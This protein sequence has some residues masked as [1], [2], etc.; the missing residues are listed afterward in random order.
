MWGK[1]DERLPHLLSHSLLHCCHLLRIHVL[2]LAL[3]THT[4]VAL[5]LCKHCLL[6]LPMHESLPLLLLVLL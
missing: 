2:H 6:L 1:V 5:L 4:H 3:E